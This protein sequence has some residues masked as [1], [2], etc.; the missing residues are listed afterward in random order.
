MRL[1]K[2]LGAVTALAL[3]ALT[4]ARV[5]TDSGVREQ[6]V[7]A[8]GAERLVNLKHSTH[9]SQRRGMVGPRAALQS[10]T[11][12]KYQYLQCEGGKLLSLMT[13]SK[14]DAENQDPRAFVTPWDNYSKEISSA[15]T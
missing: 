9:A 7:S 10:I 11:D 3:L 4:S 12:E 14:K 5:G 8:Y 15:K 6:D 2:F 13:K 1:P